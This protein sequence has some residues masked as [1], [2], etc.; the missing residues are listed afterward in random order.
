MI[1][2]GGAK[3]FARGAVTDANGRARFD[4]L[5]PGSYTVYWSSGG[6]RRTPPAQLRKPVTV[7]AG[8]KV[9]VDVDVHG[10]PDHPIITPYGAPSRRLRVV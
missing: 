2:I 7:T 6:S 9:E 4:N 5:K 3:G 10:V 1:Q 8:A